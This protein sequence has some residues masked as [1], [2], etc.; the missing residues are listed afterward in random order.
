MV[1]GRLDAR[2][3]LGLALLGMVATGCS[4]APTELPPTPTR[5]AAATLPTSL[6]QNVRAENTRVAPGVATPALPREG[7][8][9]ILTI[10]FD[11]NVHDPRL[12]TGWGFAAWLE[13]GSQAVLF[14]T[15]AG[16]TVLLDNMATL[17][18]DPKAIDIVILSHN[19]G[20][21]TGGLAGLLA[22]NHQVIVYLPQAFPAS[23]REG[24][25]AKGAVVVEVDDP[26]EILPGLW[27]TGQMGTGIVEQALVAKTAEGL[28]VLTGC[29][30]PGVDKM[31]ARARQIGQG[32]IAL[33][34]GGFHLGGASRGRVR[35][36]IAEFRRLG[37]QKVAPCHCSGNQAKE[38]LRQA[39]GEGYLAVGAG[40]Q[41]KSQ[42]VT[43]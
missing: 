33:A 21:H 23:F 12:Q 35:E 26:L 6:P 2:I 9:V 34:V 22:V 16:G 19:H 41:W 37:V 39:L 31:A 4:L 42:A 38:L 28:V 36:I 20:D 40:R 27:S 43:W 3:L 29:A 25:R 17:G 8:N 1:G 30:H 18:L 24:V 10:V 32:E 13:Y 11:N 15:G 5:V 14:D 7:E